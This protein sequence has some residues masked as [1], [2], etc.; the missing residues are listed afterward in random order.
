MYD[1]KKK[2]SKKEITLDKL[3]ELVYNHFERQKT[4]TPITSLPPP[5]GFFCMVR[6]KSLLRIKISWNHSM[7]S[8]YL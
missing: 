3:C 2:K 1:L 4:I 5:R 6:K 8:L 7:V